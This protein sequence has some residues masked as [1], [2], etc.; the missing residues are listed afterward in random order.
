[1]YSRF[2]GKRR[3]KLSGRFIIHS[4]PPSQGYIVYAKL[5][6]VVCPSS[7][8]PFGGEPPAEAY[9]DSKKI[10]EVIHIGQTRERPN[11]EIPFKLKAD[12]GYYYLGVS[13]ILF[14]DGLDGLLAQLERFCFGNAL[15]DLSSNHLDGGEFPISW[16]DTE[17]ED[18]HRYATFRPGEPP[19]YHN[20][21]GRK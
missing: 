13:V 18:M 1:M 21:G 3:Y 17:L 12:A 16:P 9:E 19:E 2:F 14:R 11:L 6:P 5:F 10:A 20:S 15:L 7:A 4:L 8:S